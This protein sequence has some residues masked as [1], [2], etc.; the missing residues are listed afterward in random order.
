M[1]TDI[2]MPARK[3][4]NDEEVADAAPV[5]L[6]S[7]RDGEPVPVV[8]GAP[9]RLAKA[10]EAGGWTVQQTYALASVPLQYFK[11]GNVKRHSHLL[12]SIAVRFQRAPAE[13]GWA[14]WTLAVDTTGDIGPRGWRFASPAMLGAERHSAK[15]IQ[16]RLAVAAP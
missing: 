7:S 4:G 12:A 9:S 8:V 13:R 11:N 5:V 14:V 3:W 10:A 1:T 15:S 16:E 6:I 2:V